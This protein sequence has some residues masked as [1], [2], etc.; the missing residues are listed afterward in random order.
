MGTRKVGVRL[1]DGKTSDLLRRKGK[2]KRTGRNRSR[3]RKKKKKKKKKKK[4]RK[5]KKKKKKWQRQRSSGKQRVA[6]QLVCGRDARGWEGGGHPPID[7]TPR[8]A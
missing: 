4:R 8:F 5:K 7:I 1:D 3:Q 2:Q 6:W